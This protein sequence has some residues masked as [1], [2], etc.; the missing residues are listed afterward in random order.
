MK[1]TIQVWRWGKSAARGFVFQLSD[2]NKFMAHFIS[3]HDLEVHVVRSTIVRMGVTKPRRVHH[4]LLFWKVLKMKVSPSCSVLLGEWI[5]RLES[6]FR[7]GLDHTAACNSP[8]VTPEFSFCWSENVRRWRLQEMQADQLQVVFVTPWD[9]SLLFF[10]PSVNVSGNWGS[11]KEGGDL[12]VSCSSSFNVFFISPEVN[13]S[14]FRKYCQCS[15][16]PLRSRYHR[17][18][19]ILDRGH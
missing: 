16:S 6:C 14:R 10:I 8:K 13:K 11:I 1:Y 4:H 19:N 7:E 2:P 18:D 3:P 17:N 15:E 5:R 9:A 12:V